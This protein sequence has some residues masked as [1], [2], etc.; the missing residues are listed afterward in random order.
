MS[1]KNTFHLHTLFHVFSPSLSHNR[2]RPENS[3][4]LFL[5]DSQNLRTKSL[6]SRAENIVQQRE[7]FFTTPREKESQRGVCGTSI[8]NKIFSKRQPLFSCQHSFH[9]TERVREREFYK[10]EILLLNIKVELSC[11]WWRASGEMRW[12]FFSLLEAFSPPHPHSI[13][14]SKSFFL[15]KELKMESERVPFMLNNIVQCVANIPSFSSSSQFLCDASLRE[16]GWE[17]VVKMLNDKENKEWNSTIQFHFDKMMMEPR[18][19][20]NKAKITLHEMG[21][22]HSLS[23]CTGR[24]CSTLLLRILLLSVCR[25]CFVLSHSTQSFLPFIS[26]FL[27]SS[28]VRT[29][30]CVFGWRKY[31]RN[32]EP[33]NNLFYGVSSNLIYE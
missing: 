22:F 9:H 14:L 5:S 12:S 26:P 11:S 2:R 7:N 17:I 28:S 13:T 31:P 16:N 10:L 33:N 19:K 18:E 29:I 6:Y 27:F 24:K 4:R 25:M 8:K 32:S 20:W 30:E 23:G 3:L 1:E 15:L 21:L